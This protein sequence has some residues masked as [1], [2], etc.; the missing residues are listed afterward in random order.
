MN[1]LRPLS[2]P[3]ACIDLRW[4]KYCQKTIKQQRY[5]VLCCG[6]VILLLQKRQMCNQRSPRWPDSLDADRVRARKRVHVRRFPSACVKTI[7]RLTVFSSAATEHIIDNPLTD[8]KP[9]VC[10]S[11][12]LCACVC[13]YRVWKISPP[14]NPPRTNLLDIPRTISSR[15]QLSVNGHGLL[16]Y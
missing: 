16:V 4:Q 2:I 12:S 15:C 13:L 5:A 6:L 7:I 8:R 9:S 10:L 3:Q 14:E 11:V 1:V